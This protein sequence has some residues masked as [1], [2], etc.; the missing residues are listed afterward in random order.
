[1]SPQALSA[2]MGVG[3]AGCDRTSALC[4]RDNLFS[5]EL[6]LTI[7]LPTLH[8]V[9]LLEKVIE[10]AKTVIAAL[11]T[12]LPDGYETVWVN[13]V[14]FYQIGQKQQQLRSRGAAAILIL[15]DNT[16][17]SMPQTSNSISLG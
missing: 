5:L 15:D 8:Q 13:E 17:P 4:S 16:T 11:C 14:V 2:L 7:A 6:Q 9:L 3:L 10:V 12:I 1:M